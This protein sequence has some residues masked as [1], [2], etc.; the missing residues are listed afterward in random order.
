MVVA[1]GVGDDSGLLLL[2]T[3]KH[4]EDAEVLAV[5]VVLSQLQLR[6]ALLLVV[7]EGDRLVLFATE[8]SCRDSVVFDE[9]RVTKSF[10]ERELVGVETMPSRCKYLARIDRPC[11][12]E[13]VVLL[14]RRPS[15]LVFVCEVAAEWR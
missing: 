7:V 14:A 3:R 5:L 8:S 12:D 15:L 1:V 2:S 10:T 11:K 9:S 4:D 13:D 6:G